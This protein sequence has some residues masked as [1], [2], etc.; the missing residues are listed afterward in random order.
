ME[1][2]LE[3]WLS[4]VDNT[5]ILD[6]VLKML[7]FLSVTG[8]RCE[9]SNQFFPQDSNEGMNPDAELLN[10]PLVNVDY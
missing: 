10:F 2:E 6:R 5:F 7:T 3:G 1:H 9:A 8:S 4:N